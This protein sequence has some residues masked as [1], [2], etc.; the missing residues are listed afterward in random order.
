LSRNCLIKHVIRVTI[1]GDI[2]GTGR[3]G[4]RRKQLLD[5]LKEMRSYYNLSENLLDRTGLKT[6]F[7][8]ECGPVVRRDCRIKSKF[9]LGFRFNSSANLCL[10]L[11]HISKI[12][13][14]S[15]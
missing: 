2:E 9:C 6:R 13:L 5:G 10:N 14:I 1:E 3:K 11:N 7:G 4:R 12:F 8:R 15:L